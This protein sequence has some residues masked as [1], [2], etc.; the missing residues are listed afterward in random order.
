M[1]SVLILCAQ[2]CVVLCSVSSSTLRSSFAAT[3]CS[4]CSSESK[5]LLC[6]TDLRVPV[7]LECSVPIEHRELYRSPCALLMSVCSVVLLQWSYSTA[8]PCA[9]VLIVV[10]ALIRV[11]LA[12]PCIYSFHALTSLD[13]AYRASCSGGME[14][15]ENGHCCVRWPQRRHS[16]ALTTRRARRESGPRR[17]QQAL[18]SAA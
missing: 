12:H 4:S 9:L 11:T 16:R 14:G 10:P 7:L 5:L 15:R 17:D 1:C 3:Q 18:A 6:S 13:A 8:P 2:L